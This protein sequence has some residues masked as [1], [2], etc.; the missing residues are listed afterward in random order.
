MSAGVFS[1]HGLFVCFEGGEGA[2]KSTQLAALAER[3]RAEGRDV[4]VTREPGATRVGE[5]IRSLVLEPTGDGAPSAR[6]EA[7]L[8]A[9]DRAHHVAT[10]VRPA[11]AVLKGFDPHGEAQTVEATDL[12]ARAFQHE[13][14]H[15]DGKVFIDRLRGIKRDLIVRRIQKL[16]RAGKW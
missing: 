5:R 10:V 13:M 6:A 4:V 2:G 1:E 15:L 7:L 8:Y 11:R 12:L 3:L 14:D 16:K 9:A